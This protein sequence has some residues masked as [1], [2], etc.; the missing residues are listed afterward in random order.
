[1]AWGGFGCFPGEAGVGGEKEAVKM[2][3]EWGGQE[4]NLDSSVQI[5]WE[6]ARCSGER[7]D[8]PH[9]DGGGRYIS[10]HL[11]SE[12]QP[13]RHDERRALKKVTIF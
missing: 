4:L 13:R 12:L 10:H 7:R 3:R 5:E 1:M 8:Q 2:P 11:S 9:Q 6:G